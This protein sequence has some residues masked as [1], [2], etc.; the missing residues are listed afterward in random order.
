MATT[1]VRSYAKEN[2]V[3]LFRNMYGWMTL[4]LLISAL[5][6]LVMNQLLETSTTV[7]SFVFSGGFWGL[8][9]VEFI[10][11]I[12]LT[13]GLRK[14]AFSTLTVLF[15]LY[16]VI[17][18]V[19]LTP[20]L[21]IYTQESI[22]STFLITAGAFGGMAFYGSLT[23][24]DLSSIGSIALMAL[25]G[26]IIAMVVNLFLHS[27]MMNLIISCVGVVVFALLT[28]YDAQKYKRLISSYDG[29]VCEEVQKIALMGAFELYLDFINM[30]LHLLRLL[31]SRK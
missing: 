27:G 28:L 21:L 30:F 23:K 6:A 24:K 25:L 13:A 2:Q 18:G 31:G 26:L 3:T 19:T 16:S 8:M 17:N 12:S 11:V 15:I 14:F 29:E 9:V 1:Y 20:I 22:V 4:A 7:Q 5:S 10:L